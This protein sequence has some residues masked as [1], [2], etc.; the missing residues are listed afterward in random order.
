VQVFERRVLTY[1]PS[2]PSGWQVEAGN[3]GQHYYAW[4]YVQLGL[5]ATTDP[6]APAAWTPPPP[7]VNVQASATVSNPSPTDGSTETVS[8]TFLNNGQGV[9]GVEMDTTWHD[10]TTTSYCSAITGSDGVASCSRDIGGATKGYTVVIDVA[11]SWQ[12]QTYTASTSFTPQ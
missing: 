6:N 5:T 3:V 12:G 8:G 7:A 1:T 10:K 11:F 2:N 4:R 9:A